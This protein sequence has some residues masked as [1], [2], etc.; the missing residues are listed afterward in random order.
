MRPSLP[1]PR[2]DFDF[3]SR[4]P[5]V[6]EQENKQKDK[7]M[8]TMNTEHIVTIHVSPYQDDEMEDISQ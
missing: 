3:I 8:N 7:T 2:E 1:Q 4:G 6:G 5:H